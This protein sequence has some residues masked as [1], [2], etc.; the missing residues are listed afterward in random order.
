MTTL[1]SRIGFEVE[2][3]APRGSSRRTLAEELATRSGGELLP[4]WHLD[5]EPVPLESLGGRFLHLTHGFEVRRAGGEQLCTLVDDITIAADLDPTAPAADG[6]H[7]LLTDDIRLARL[8]DRQCDPAAGIEAVL[9]PVARLW[10]TPVETIGHIRRLD[11]AGATVV[12]AA[13]AGG[14]RERPC[15]IVTPPLT[16]DH[17]DALEELLAP[18]RE[19]GFVVPRE[20]AIHLHVDGAPYRN[21][22]ALANVVRLFGYWREPLRELLGTN[23]QCRRLAPLPDEL[24]A[25]VAG[26]PTYDELRAA[27]KA[28]GLTKFYDVNLTQLFRDDPIRDTLEIRILPGAISAE[29]VVSRAAVVEELLQRCLDPAPIARPRENPPPSPTFLVSPGP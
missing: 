21:P 25:A 10:G 29:D 12:L 2:L 28:G 5:S 24:V 16:A 23:P 26:E 18:A 1:H 3:L 17:G 9:D 6:W 22:A 13:P 4:V 7:R 8:L 19:L 27:A 15:E 20:A 11:V 14:E